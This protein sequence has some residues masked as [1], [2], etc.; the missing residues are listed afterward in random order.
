MDETFVHKHKLLVV[1]LSKAIPVEAIDRRMLSSG[2]VTENTTPLLI[3]LG[4]HKEVLTFYIV[5]CFFTHD[6]KQNN[7]MVAY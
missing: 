7:Y 1:R 6:M 2:A 4:N 5:V 3:Q